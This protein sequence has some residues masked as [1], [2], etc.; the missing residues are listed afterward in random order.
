MST[1]SIIQVIEN[2]EILL[3]HYSQ[4]DGYPCDFTNKGITG[5]GIETLS[6]LLN[7]DLNQFVENLR[8]MN[9]IK[10]KDFREQLKKKKPKAYDKF[11]IENPHLSVNF[12]TKI[13]TAIYN[14][15]INEILISKPSES[16]YA[17]LYIIDITNKTFKVNFE[18]ERIKV[19][20]LNN[21]PTVIQFINDFGRDHEHNWLVE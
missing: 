15:E 10:F 5:V 20:D 12:G 1:R 2:D 6:F 8:E 18:G 13:L 11:F 19:Y 7:H 4:C 17:G 21:L 3:S 9:Q 16:D 14:K